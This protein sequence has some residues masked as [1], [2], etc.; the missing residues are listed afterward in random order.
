MTQKYYKAAISFANCSEDGALEKSVSI[1]VNHLLGIC[2]VQ[3]DY[4]EIVALTSNG[5]VLSTEEYV[6]D[7]K[8]KYNEKAKEKQGWKDVI[9]IE[10][11]A[12]Y[13]LRTAGRLE[14]ICKGDCLVDKKMCPQHVVGTGI[15]WRNIKDFSMFGNTLVSLFEDGTV[16]AVGANE[17]EECNC[18]WKNVISIT[19]GYDNVAGLK[20]DGTVLVAGSIN[21]T[22]PSYR[23]W[24]DIISIALSGMTIV[25]LKKDGSVVSAGRNKYNFSNWP[26]EIIKIISYHDNVFG[27]SRDGRVFHSGSHSVDDILKH[28][29]GIVSIFATGSSGLVALTCKGTVIYHDHIYGAAT[30]NWKD[31]VWL[32][33]ETNYIIGVD[34]YGQLHYSGEDELDLAR[35]IAQWKLFEHIDNVEKDRKLLLVQHFISRNAL[36]FNI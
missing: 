19:S 30:S 12:N 10:H 4:L 18:D 14:T 2:W 13:A 1:W 34:I 26:H 32:S 21:S 28:W 36:K 23:S 33:A 3:K 22:D 8:K 17:N 11:H 7:G 24:K 9:K 16:K 29:R 31:I 25:G 27:I 35:Q 20:E 6:F 5:H 15:E